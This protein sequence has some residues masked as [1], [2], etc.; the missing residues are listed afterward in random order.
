MVYLVAV[1]LVVL[2]VLWLE[3]QSAMRSCLARS[4]GQVAQTVA[5]IGR[6]RSRAQRRYVSFAQCFVAPVVRKSS[7]GNRYWSILEEENSEFLDRHNYYQKD[8]R[9]PLLKTDT[10]TPVVKRSGWASIKAAAVAKSPCTVSDLPQISE[11]K[12]PTFAVPGTATG[13]PLS[14]QPRRSSNFELTQDS[15]DQD[16]SSNIPAR[17]MSRP[18]ISLSPSQP[19]L[20]PHAEAGSDLLQQIPTIEI[21]NNETER[22]LS[23]H[24][25]NSGFEWYQS[26]SFSSSTTTEDMASPTSVDNYIHRLEEIRMAR[27][28]SAPEV[29]CDRLYLRVASDAASTVSGQTLVEDNGSF[30]TPGMD[31]SD[32]AKI[33]D[34]QVE[35]SRLRKSPELAPDS[36]EIEEVSRILFYMYP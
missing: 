12:S 6:F 16:I 9:G 8:S 13:A 19:L 20:K 21:N 34:T 17:F 22:V 1:F 18:S 26:S 35:H 5:L 29:D 32:Q 7:R 3:P 2:S 36:F 33:T 25:N 24:S 28:M 14:G 23:R 10:K 31:T 11:K 4:F 30:E 27:R 15:V